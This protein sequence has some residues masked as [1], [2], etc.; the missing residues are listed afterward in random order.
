[1]FRF[2]RTFKFAGRGRRIGA[3]AAP[4]A[5]M[6]A[7]ETGEQSWAAKTTKRDAE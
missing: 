2:K 7:N 1:M 6:L 4:L 5:R 3:L